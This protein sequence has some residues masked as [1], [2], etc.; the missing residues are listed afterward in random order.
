[1]QMFDGRTKEHLNEGQSLSLV[2]TG[3]DSTD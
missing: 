3:D 2:A 1:M